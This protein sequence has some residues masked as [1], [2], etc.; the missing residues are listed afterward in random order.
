MEQIW[1]EH[2]NWLGTIPE[3]WRLKWEI[4]FT[5][6]KWKMQVTANWIRIM[7]KHF[8]PKNK[9]TT[10]ISWCR[11]LVTWHVT[12]L[13]LEVLLKDTNVGHWS[14]RWK[15]LSHIRIKETFW[16]I[17]SLDMNC[18]RERTY[19]LIPPVH[20]WLSVQFKAAALDQKDLARKSTN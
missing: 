3:L 15:Q 16:T 1:N 19:R 11:R 18:L 17:W 4:L 12:V 2:W 5:N 7:E 14:T 13:I 8:L 6:Q 20:H 9:L 10:G